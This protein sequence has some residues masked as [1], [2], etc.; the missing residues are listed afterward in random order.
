MSVDACAL[1]KPCNVTVRAAG[2]SDFAVL[3]LL[4]M[5]RAFTAWPSKSLADVM[6]HERTRR[7]KTVD[8]D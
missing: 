8:E 3:L 2:V 4:M 6:R 5:V 1:G 7:K